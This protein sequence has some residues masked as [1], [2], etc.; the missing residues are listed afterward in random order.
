M[1]I[2]TIMARPFFFCFYILLFYKLMMIIIWRSD[3]EKIAVNERLLVSTCR[4]ILLEDNDIS[5][6]YLEN[7]TFF[8]K[9]IVYE[10]DLLRALELDFNEVGKKIY[11]F[12]EGFQKRPANID[13]SL[14]NK[15]DCSVKNHFQIV[16]K[17]IQVH[18]WNYILYCD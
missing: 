12:N 14:N 10:C 11:I 13:I 7:F 6:P 4:S 16:V 15:L 18:V 8:W 1:I 3:G 9:W 17:I 5:N 2:T